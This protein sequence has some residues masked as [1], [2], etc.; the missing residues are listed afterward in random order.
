MRVFEVVIK[1]GENAGI[2]PRQEEYISKLLKNFD[3]GHALKLLNLSGA[4]EIE[5]LSKKQASALI[6][7]M[8][9]FLE[10]GV[11]TKKQ[12]IENYLKE[13]YQVAENALPKGVSK[14][15]KADIAARVG[16]ILFWENTHRKG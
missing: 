1:M 9:I 16:I 11:Q 2:T 7:V 12:E 14:D 3:V 5:Y 4:E 13:G 6:E 8:H 15:V 10:A